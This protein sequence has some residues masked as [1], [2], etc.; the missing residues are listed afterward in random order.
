MYETMLLVV[1]KRKIIRTLIRFAPLRNGS[2]ITFHVTLTM[3]MKLRNFN[4]AW[5]NR[6]F[7][8]EY[9]R[10]VKMCI[11]M[12]LSYDWFPLE[13]IFIQRFFVIVRN[14]FQKLNIY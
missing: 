5:K 8:Q 11:Y 2:L 9:Q 10:E 14:K 4:S 12:C 1:L 6:I 3:F 13:F 7:Q